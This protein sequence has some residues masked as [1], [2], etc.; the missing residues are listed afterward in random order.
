LL[1]AVYKPVEVMVPSAEPIDQVTPALEGRFK[2]EN[3]WVPEGTT[4]AVAGLTLV[5]VPTT[6][7]GVEVEMAGPSKMVALAALAGL[8]RLV[9]EI[10]T[11]VSTLT[12]LGAEYSPVGDMV[13]R[14]CVIAHVTCWLEVPPTDAIN[15]WD[16]PPYR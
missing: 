8:A 5:G 14:P 1:G 12:E 11:K 16:W 13:P 3:C 7:G 2:T 15:C 6:G 9:A 4:L 10:V